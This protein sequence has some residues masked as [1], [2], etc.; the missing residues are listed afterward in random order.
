MWNI[1]RLYSEIR[2][3]CYTQ[4]IKSL[5]TFFVK[6][7]AKKKESYLF[8]GYIWW[9]LNDMLWGF[10][11]QSVT[12]LYVNT[13]ESFY[14]L[15]LESPP[16]SETR[17]GLFFLCLF[18]L[19]SF[20]QCRFGQLFSLFSGLRILIHYILSDEKFCSNICKYICWFCLES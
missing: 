17:R 2:H 11:A 12:L 10:V 8:D 18:A 4:I 20:S 6:Y 14:G 13:V 16:R 15:K 9:N 5:I 3:T 1:S 19:F 7:A